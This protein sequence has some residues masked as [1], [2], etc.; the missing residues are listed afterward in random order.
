MDK[1]QH[2]SL[3]L[4]PAQINF[5]FPE[6]QEHH[7]AEVANKHIVLCICVILAFLMSAIKLNT[8]SRVSIVMFSFDF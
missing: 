5:I 4:P 1:I 6:L 3:H 8:Y 7:K 2:K